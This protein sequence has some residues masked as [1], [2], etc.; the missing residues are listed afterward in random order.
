[1]NEIPRV[2]LVEDNR[3]DEDLA[4]LSIESSGVPCEVDV[5]RD[6][7]E[8]LEILFGAPESETDG[9]RP[10]LRLILLDLKVPKV[11]GLEVLQR[12]RSDPRTKYVPVVVLTSSS[13]ERDLVNAY[14]FGANGYI[15]KPINME[16]FDQLT[17]VIC[18]YWLHWNQI[19][20]Q[21]PDS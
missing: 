13:E 10:P 19:S 7:A 15:I 20:P 5:A 3:D 14:A 6:G 12:V 8:A 4:R 2:L 18:S 21:I 1:M 9:P 17:S 11:S 16:D